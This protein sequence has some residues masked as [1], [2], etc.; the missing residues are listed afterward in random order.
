MAGPRPQ[1]PLVLAINVSAG[2][3]V[4]VMDAPPPGALHV[5]VSARSGERP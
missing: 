5:V 4:T 1:R 3:E 2:G